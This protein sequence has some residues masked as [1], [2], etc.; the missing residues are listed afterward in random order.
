MTGRVFTDGF[1]VRTESSFKEQ[2][3]AHI[4]KPI[5]EQGLDYYNGK[6]LKSTN[7]LN[8]LGRVP[9]AADE[10]EPFHHFDFGHVELKKQPNNAM[11]LIQLQNYELIKG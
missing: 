3:A 5:R 10:N 6:E 2:K 7:N 1:G 4:W 8:E 11:P 9:H